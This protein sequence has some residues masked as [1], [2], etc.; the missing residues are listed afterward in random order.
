MSFG[1]Q[2][3]TMWSGKFPPSLFPALSPDA[4]SLLQSFLW[5]SPLNISYVSLAFSKP[6]L[7]LYLRPR[8]GNP[9]FTSHGV[10]HCL[11]WFS[12]TLST[13]LYIVLK[14][15]PLT[16]SNVNVPSVFCH[17]LL[18]Y[19]SKYQ[20]LLQELG[21]SLEEGKITFLQRG[22]ESGKQ[23]LGEVHWYMACISITVKLTP[24]VTWNE[25]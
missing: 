3:W 19:S 11:L 9:T 6:T 1:D 20:K 15:T 12:N 14:K 25:V 2:Q 5:G 16:F 22:K 13:P 23:T 8:T 24:L 7:P 10:L 18:R 21:C 17:A 4:E